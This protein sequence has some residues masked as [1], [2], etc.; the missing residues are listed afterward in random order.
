MAKTSLREFAAAILPQALGSSTMGVMKSRVR[1][2]ALRASMV[3]R[4]ASSP[5]AQELRIRSSRAR[6]SSL[7]IFDRSAG[8]IFAAQPLVVLISLSLII[9]LFSFGRG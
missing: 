8:P 1:T 2:P 5:D 9:I 3:H 4:A 6:G 7:R